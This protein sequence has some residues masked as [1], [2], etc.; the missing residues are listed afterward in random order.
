MSN[1]P[2]D[3]DALA[4]A[5]EPRSLVI[6]ASKPGTAQTVGI[7]RADIPARLVGGDGV[8]VHHRGLDYVLG[9]DIAPLQIASGSTAK[10][11]LPVWQEGTPIDEIAR[12]A[13]NAIPNDA[14]SNGEAW[15]RQDGDWVP[16]DEIVG[17]VGPTGPMGP[18]GP[19]GEIGPQGI[20][21]TPGAQGQVGPV[22][23]QGPEGAASTVP[24]PKGDT[25]SQ[26]IQGVKGDPGP[27]GIQGPGGPTGAQGPKGDKGDTGLQGTQGLQG[28]QGLKG[29]TGATGAQGP[30]GPEGPEGPQGEQGAAGTGINMKGTVPTP[31]DLPTGAANGDGYVA[32]SDGCL[33]VWDAESGV[34]N[35]LGPI[36]GPPGPTGPPG[37]Q[38]PAGVD[39]A[40]GPAGAA[41][42]QGPAGP[43]GSQGPQGVKGD[44]GSQ[45][46]QGVQGPQGVPG[47]G[48]SDGD[49]GDIVI[50]GTGTVLMLDSTVVTPAAKTV[51]DD[52]TTAEMLTTL[53]GLTQADADTRYLNT[54]GDTATGV[55]GLT[56]GTAASPALHFGSVNT[57]VFGSATV[58]S[59]SVAGS[60]KFQVASAAITAIVPVAVPAGSSTTTSLHF[61][62]AGTGLYGGASTISMAI[63]GTSRFTLSASSLILG[64]PILEPF[65]NVS[66][67]SYAFNGAATTGMYY[68]ATELDFAVSGTRKL[69]MKAADIT[70]DVPIILPAD[71]TTALQAATKQYV[72]AKD[73]SVIRLNPQTIS[74]NESVPAGYNG[75]TAGPITIAS[76]V[77]VDVASGSQWTIV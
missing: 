13:V 24:G 48:F 42:A 75:V 28:P 66:A 50:S 40:V 15:A 62:T 8:A 9:L 76:G 4:P 5:Q 56:A 65:G 51:L 32:D 36:Q 39:G 49:K 26:G 71:P 68:V 11:W 7:G 20:P 63:A 54:A 14:P 3:P 77:T 6:P 70:V 58:V 41:G 69:S 43:T 16:V 72:D 73:T 12:V 61:G 53:G 34:W 59:M 45:G 64:A 17:P 74:A 25:G 37:I 38:G 35:N 1:S 57:G 2:L 27:Q 29:D 55:I 33:Y 30:V 67:P 18:V 22:G 44:T 60:A 23:P 47:V 31:G 19:P 21:G 52:T 10:Q 46:S